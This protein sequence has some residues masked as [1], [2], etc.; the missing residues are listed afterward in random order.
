M[1]KKS[2]AMILVILMIAVL[3]AC[4]GASA[5]SPTNA[6]DTFLK[7][8]KAQDTETVSKVYSG[9]FEG[10]VGEFESGGDEEYDALIEEELIP[11]LLDYDYEVSNEQIDEDTATV[12]VALTTYD[13]GGAYSDFVEELFQALIS[14]Q[15][16]DLTED[17][18]T[19][20]G[21]SIFKDKLE[22]LTEKTYEAKVTISLTNTE[23]GWKVDSL[24]DDTTFINALSGGLLTASESL[25]GGYGG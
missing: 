16:T 6:A 11:K 1:L 18:I 5:S 13:L 19:E 3:A 21:L 10:L 14:M 17:D 25:L 2:T 24:D 12:D 9:T 20:A 22:G 7:A 4:G 23:E 8:V 15:T